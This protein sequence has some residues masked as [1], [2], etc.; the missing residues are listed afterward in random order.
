MILLG[1]KVYDK[2]TGVEGIAVARTEWISGCARITI[3]PQELKDGK[4]V[5]TTTVDEPLLGICENQPL[6]SLQK[7]KEVLTGGPQESPSQ[8]P[9][10]VS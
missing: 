10:P 3:Q 6:V 8:K 2:I 4:P 5:E 1:T 9:S 7:E